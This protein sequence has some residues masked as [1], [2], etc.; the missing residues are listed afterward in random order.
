M[1]SGKG[2]N[3]Q[4]QE[5]FILIAA[6]CVKEEKSLE[7]KNKTPKHG[8]H[9]KALYPLMEGKLHDKLLELRKNGKSIKSWWFNTREKQLVT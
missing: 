7:N 2:E 4:R 5:A 1:T 8:C 6:N 9:C 3:I